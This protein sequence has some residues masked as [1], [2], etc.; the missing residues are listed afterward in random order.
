MRYISEIKLIIRG[1]TCTTII[2]ALAAAVLVLGNWRPAFLALKTHFRPIIT[3]KVAAA[4]GKCRNVVNWP[5]WLSSSLYR[6]FLGTR[7][8]LLLGSL[9]H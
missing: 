7:L 6:Q 4:R 3:R 5:V 9:E 8:L 2:V 1:I